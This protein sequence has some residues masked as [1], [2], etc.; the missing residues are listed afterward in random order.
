MRL[1]RKIGKEVLKTIKI[2]L[3]DPKLYKTCGHLLS[4]AVSSVYERMR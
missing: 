1:R 3:V 2:G 4:S